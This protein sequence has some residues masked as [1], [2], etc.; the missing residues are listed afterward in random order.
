MNKLDLKSVFPLFQASLE[1]AAD[2][3]DFPCVFCG[4]DTQPRFELGIGADIITSCTPCG[5]LLALDADDRKGGSC[6]RCKKVVAFPLT[7]QGPLSCCANCLREGR[8][9]ITKD[10]ELGMVTWEHA[11]SGWT[12]GLPGRIPVG[13]EV[14][15]PNA[16]GWRQ[17]KVDRSF[18]TEL[19]RTP[20]YSTIQGDQWLFCC[21]APMNFIGTWSRE[22]FVHEAIGG[23]GRDLFNKIVERAVP[24]LWEDRLHDVTGIYVFQCSQCLKRRAHCDIA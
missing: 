15:E 24:G 20:T 1:D 8:A 11:K 6:P 21:R 9:A 13:W 22:R 23:D 4:N 2:V 3:C 12:H 19:L 18:I 17:V 5:E 14:S 16:D 7:T 10:T